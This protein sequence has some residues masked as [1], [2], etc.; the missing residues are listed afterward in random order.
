MPGQLSSTEVGFL[1]DEELQ[2][3]IEARGGVA[4]PLVENRRKQLRKLIQKQRRGSIIP[5]VVKVEPNQ[6]TMAQV[7]LGLNDLTIIINR[8]QGVQVLKE[9]A[10]IETRLTHYM[11]RVKTW[12]EDVEEIKDRKENT[13]AQIA[14]LFQK[15]DD[16][17]K[18]VTGH[19]FESEEENSDFENEVHDEDNH[20][21]AGSEHSNHREVVHEIVPNVMEEARPNNVEP[22][23]RVE[24][25]R[26][27]D[28]PNVVC[29]QNN[30]V[31]RK[32]P[33]MYNWNLK[34]SGDENSMS[35]ETFLEQIEMKRRNKALNHKEIFS[36][37][38]ELL[39]GGARKW[40]LANYKQITTWFEFQYRI[41]QAY[42]NE[43]QNIIMWRDV[44][45]RQ[46]QRG[47]RV[48]DYVTK[49]RLLF[50]RLPVPMRE[51]MM[52]DT[53]KANVL[54]M[55]RDRLNL[56]R[57][58]TVDDVEEI[59]LL[60]ERSHQSYHAIDYESEWRDPN[61]NRDRRYQR[62]ENQRHYN[63]RNNEMR[64]VSAPNRDQRKQ[65]FGYR[66]PNPRYQPLYENQNYYPNFRQPFNPSHRYAYQPTRGN[67]LP[68][69]PPYQPPQQNIPAL[70]AP[71]NLLAIEDSARRNDNPR[72]RPRVYCFNCGKPNVTSYNCKC[73]VAS[74][75][76]N[77]NAHDGA[78]ANL[79]A[80]RK[81]ILRK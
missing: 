65:N 36:G 80:S 70:P 77:D 12:N 68:Y 45:N 23:V 48:I 47:E 76:G 14:T 43:S 75:S 62:P 74:T 32:D 9:R 11:S 71:P 72:I 56:E 26:V 33:K 1:R 63:S 37:I 52:I 79:G 5:E 67:R 41:T 28:I 16:A 2:Y 8:L 7:D 17:I 53:L 25:N 31:E 61:E 59:M 51:S 4:Q 57:C 10:R 20:S 44:L 34:F 39:I 54:P 3:E 15:L 42:G 30:Q 58:T 55:Y 27:N 46:Q 73:N 18:M 29:C 50:N 38:P 40:Y 60:V 78:K 24:E 21:E 35:I 19:S 49:M 64:H 13:L 6:A 69:A 66:P 81:Q 22:V